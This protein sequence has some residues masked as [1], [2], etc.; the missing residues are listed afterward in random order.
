MVIEVSMVRLSLFFFSFTLLFIYKAKILLRGK[1]KIRIMKMFSFE[2]HQQNAI[3]SYFSH[4]TQ[5]YLRH[6]WTK[7]HHNY[8]WINFHRNHNK[9]NTIMIMMIMKNLDLTKS[10]VHTIH[11][12]NK[13]KYIK[14]R[15]YQI[16]NWTH[17]L[18]FNWIRIHNENNTKQKQHSINKTQQSTEQNP[19][20]INPREKPSIIITLLSEPPA[21]KGRRSQARAEGFKVAEGRFSASKVTLAP[22]GGTDVA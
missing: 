10:K 17:Q 14:N 2:K 13:K 7:Q 8:N 12:N 11:I 22:K 9:L 5:H 6:T 1:S 3:S 21:T 15:F 18:S 20:L 4:T 19:T 16:L